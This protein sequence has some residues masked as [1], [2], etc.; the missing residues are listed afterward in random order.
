MREVSRDQDPQIASGNLQ[1]EEEV[2]KNL[3]AFNP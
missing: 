2:L 1:G 3:Q